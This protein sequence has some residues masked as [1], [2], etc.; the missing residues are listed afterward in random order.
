MDWVQILE[1]PFH[2]AGCTAKP[3]PEQITV[4]P[5]LV[6]T[7]VTG[8]IDAVYRHRWSSVGPVRALKFP[9]LIALGMS[10]R[11]AGWDVE[12]LV[13]A[14]KL[15]LSTDE[16]PVPA[17][18]HPTDKLGSRALFHILRHATMR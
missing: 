16:V 10:D 2:R 11:G 17:D 1:P 12:M 18:D 7:V 4:Y 3:V 9:A 15:G 6:M 14:L 8:L 5:L 13:R